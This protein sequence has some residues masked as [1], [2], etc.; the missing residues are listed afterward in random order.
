LERIQPAD[1]L[2]GDFFDLKLGDSKMVRRTGSKSVLLIDDDPHIHDLVIF[3]L[4]DRVGGIISAHDARSGLSLA[5]QESPALI[6]LDIRMPDE[7]GVSLC[8]KLQNL[9]ETREIPVVFLTGCEEQD[10]LAQ[11]FDAGAVDYIRKPICRT[12]LHARVMARLRA[13]SNLD[14]IREQARV[15]G[16]TGLGNRSALDES[17]LERS[18]NW[19]KEGLN[20]SLAILD[21]DH[22]KKVN[23][24][25]GHRMGDQVL[26]ASASSF[27]RISRPCDSLFRYG[28]DEF[29]VIIPE[30]SSPD[31]LR[32]VQR[33]VES[34]DRLVL[35]SAK[36][37]VRV[38]CSAGLITPSGSQAMLEL[39]QIFE[40]ADQ[41]LYQA[42]KLGRNRAVSYSDIA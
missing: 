13:K 32:V 18:E 9:P 20:F 41:A 17:L 42:K 10:Q 5:I 19:D 35:P 7:D 23:D 21:L 12:E 15:D 40:F 25:Y 34:I 14:R 36:G 16:L 33:M 1:E 6:L 8:R 24:E 38:T 27:A 3:H 11:A 29:V 22:F 28:G 39:S 37:E 2:V 30:E 26:S 4:E 31:A